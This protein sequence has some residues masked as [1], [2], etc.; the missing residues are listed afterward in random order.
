MSTMDGSARERVTVELQWILLLNSLSAPGSLPQLLL[1]SI[2]TNCL[3]RIPQS[4]GT[5]TN[6]ISKILQSLSSSETS[7]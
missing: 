2:S 1:F 4:H 6:F 7:P 5:N 3:R